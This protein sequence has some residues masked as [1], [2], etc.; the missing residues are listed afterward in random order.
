M[1]QRKVDFLTLTYLDNE[2]LPETIIDSIESRKNNTAWWRVY[3]LGLLGD[4]EG[5]IYTGWRAVDDVPFEAKLVKRGLDFGYSND[6]TAIVDVYEHNGGFILD[7]QLYQKGL[8]NQEIANFVKSL[9]QANTLIVADSSEPKSID[10]LRLYG[11][12]ILPANK[13]AGS[14]NQGITFIQGSKMSYTKRSINLSKEQRNYMW[15]KDKNTDKYINKAQDFMNHLL[16]ALRYALE[17]Y[18]TPQDDDEDATSG[19]ITSLWG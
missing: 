9:P 19:S 16:D 8:S 2:G 10:E 13:G 14:I 1:E 18:S 6:P 15:L 17:T 11:L 5:L 4:V 7:E 12:N 3:G